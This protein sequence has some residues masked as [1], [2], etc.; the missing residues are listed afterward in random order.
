MTVISTVIN[1][2]GTVHASDSLITLRQSNGTVTQ[3]NWRRTK[4][5]KVERFRGAIS[6]FGLATCDQCRWSTV[7]WLAKQSR[8]AADFSS[9]E[10][11]A[12]ALRDELN[13]EMKRM[14]FADPRSYG[15]GMH[16]T[17]YENIDNKWIPEL[18]LIT[19]FTDPSYKSIHAHGL[20]VSRETYHTIVNVPAD[21][22]HRETR[23]R[24]TV[25]DHLHAADNMLIYN[26]GDPLMFNIAANAILGSFAT[27]AKRGHLS[28]SRDLRTYLDIARRPVQIVSEAQRHFCSR[29]YRTVGG[30]PHDLGIS[31]QGEYYSTTGDA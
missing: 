6:Y 18:F 30:K 24:L 13:R 3:L 15:I 1:R 19:N 9:A 22:G 12:N 21:M 27:I 25:Y 8:A 5:V 2:Y 29:S 11:F 20:H 31:P 28:G 26:N 14:V 16:F 17:V 7:S 10:E 23:F 4:I